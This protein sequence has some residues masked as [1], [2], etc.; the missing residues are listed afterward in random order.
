[1]ASGKD[2][3]RDELIATANKIA[4][5]GKGILAADESTGTIGKR[6]DGIQV[7]NNEE[8]RRAYRDLLFNTK[9]LENYISGV[10][11]YEETLFQNDSNGVPFVELLAKKGIITGIKTDLG[12]RP[13][14]GT[15]GETYTQGFDD[16]AVRCKKY[17]DQGARFCKW[18]AVLKIGDGCPSAI[19][20]KENVNGLARYAAISQVCL[21]LLRS[22]LL[23]LFGVGIWVV[24]YRL[25]RDLYSLSSDSRSLLFVV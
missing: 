4:T 22:W 20:V 21:V 16:L 12:V 6:F 25:I 10:I 11:M 2:Q 19:A 18:R 9:G 8:N 3:F 5:A 14:R 24:N 23:F 15:D 17:Y 13:I 1:M 7:E